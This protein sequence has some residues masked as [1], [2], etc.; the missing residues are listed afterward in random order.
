MEAL[1][2]YRNDLFHWGFEWPVHMRQQFQN[3]TAGWPAGWFEAVT[4]GS[5]PWMFSMSATFVDHC[6]NLAEE[7]VVGLEDFLV[8]AA[9][10][11]DGLPP[12][13]PNPPIEGVRLA[14]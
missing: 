8:D 1:F 6:M 9:R 3:V 2:R 12:L 7:V 10:L 13:G 14:S 5:E 4:I 11:E